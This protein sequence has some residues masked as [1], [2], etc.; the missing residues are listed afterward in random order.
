V[1]LLVDVVG[2]RPLEEKQ[3]AGK[4]RFLNESAA[5]FCAATAFTKPRPFS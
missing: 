3:I 5:S 2:Q 4:Q 1:K